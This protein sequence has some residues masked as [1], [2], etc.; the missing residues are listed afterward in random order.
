MKLS[1]R[2]LLEHWWVLPVL[3]TVGAFAGMGLYARRVT[4]GKREPGP[5]AYRAGEPLRVAAPEDLAGPYDTLEFAY[6]GTPCILVEL[7][8]ASETA[9]AVSGRHFIAF[10]RL[11]THLGC[12]VNPVRDT[13]LLAL[14]YNFRTDSP[15]LGCPCHYNV[16]D[17]AREGASVFGRALFPLPR[18]QLAS[19]S[20]ALWAVGIEADPRTGV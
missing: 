12:P 4:F 9:L 10:S 5:P 18:V 17:P 16:F 14:A 19:R 3:G 1:R 11:C 8:Q 6:A 20:G 2:R 7:P 13:E 15:K